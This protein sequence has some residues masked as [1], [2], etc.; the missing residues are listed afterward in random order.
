MR[1]RR[2]WVGYYVNNIMH[3]GNRSSN[4][5]ESMHANI[6]RS[7]NTSSGRMSVVT[8]KINNWIK[9]RVSVIAG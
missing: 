1:K 2:F 3:M 6:K 4:R 5:V 7:I 9:M 8:K